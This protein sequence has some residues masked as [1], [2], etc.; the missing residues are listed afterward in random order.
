MAR[1]LDTG[2][3]AFHYLRRFQQVH[4][5]ENAAWSVAEDE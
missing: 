4:N 5:A 3:S 2:R 1:E